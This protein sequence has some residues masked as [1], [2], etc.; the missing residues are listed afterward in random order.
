MNFSL[1]VNL[2]AFLLAVTALGAPVDDVYKLGP[3]SMPQSG[4]PQGRVIGPETLPSNIFTNTTRHYW[5]YV[6]AQ[7][8]SATP[9]A[10]VIFQDG[11]A[12]LNTNGDY[13]IPQVLDNL[14]YRR[15]I[16]VTIAVFINPGRTPDQPESSSTN[17]GDSINNRRLEYNAL[18]DKYAK[19]IVDELLPVITK[20]FN[21]ST[22]PENRAIGGASSGAICAFTVAWH[23][24]DQF[25]KVIS[26]IGSFTD[27]MGGHV[28]P[29]I[30][31]QSERKPIR[32]FL[33]DGANDNRGMRRGGGEYNPKRDWYSQNRK[34]VQA[35]TEKDYDVNYSWGIGSHSN[36][37]GG[38]IMPEIIRWLWRDYPRPEDPADTTYRT[39]FAPP[40]E[41][42]SGN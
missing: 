5:I 11:H 30:I 4:V 9:A 42:S 29:D 1:S 23:R 12:F 6:P 2:A 31:R 37:H 32:I 17:W 16:P 40:S 7:Y 35:L 19:L 33:Q 28:Y 36:K 22:N 25:R 27:I 21:I 41:P 14:I 18:D 39:L 20:R 34:M 38:V 8:Q 24:P 15:E 10:L 3:D 13:R 26:T